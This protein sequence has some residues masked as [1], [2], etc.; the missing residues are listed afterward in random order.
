MNSKHFIL[1]SYIVGGL[2]LH[3]LNDSTGGS[4]NFAPENALF[5]ILKIDNLSTIHNLADI[6]YLPNGTCEIPN[7]ASIEE[8]NYKDYV[9]A[10]LNNRH[11]RYHINN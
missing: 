4:I 10:C 5:D 6:A 8:E 7:L 11:L 9:R 3:T 1:G 2:F